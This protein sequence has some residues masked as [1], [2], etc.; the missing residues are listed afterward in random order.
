MNEKTINYKHLHALVDADILLF[1][2]GMAGQYILRTAYLL[3]LPEH[4]LIT[5]RYKADLLQWLKD[6]DIALEEVEIIEK[7]VIEPLP[8]VLHTIKVMLKNMQGKFGDMTLYL[9]E[10]DNFRDRVA[11]ELPYKGNRWSVE[12]RAEDRQEGKWIEWL[13]STEEK[14]KPP[15]RPYWEKEI[16]EYLYENY[17]TVGVIGQEADDQLSIIQHQ[18]NKPLELT[19]QE[20]AKTIIVSIDKDLDMVLGW[21]QKLSAIEE[22]PYWVDQFTADKNF[23]GQLLTGDATDNIGGIKGIGPKKRDKILKDCNSIDNMYSTVIAAYKTAYPEDSIDKLIA[24]IK[25]RGTLLWIRRE[26]DQDW[27]MPQEVRFNSE[28]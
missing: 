23:Y 4:P 13:D 6:K 5:L 20:T 3:D 28:E 1:R 12:K 14:Y 7:Q 26:A 18:K 16:K 17:D 15:I 9:S 10:G 19:C 21:H 8:L 25:E 11:T 27:S 24:K 2:A 22:P